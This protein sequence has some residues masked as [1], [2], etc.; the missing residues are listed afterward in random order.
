MNIK[1]IFNQQ[2]PAQN[3]QS[4]SSVSS[5]EVNTVII[6]NTYSARDSVSQIFTKYEILCDY[7][8]KTLEKHDREKLHRTQLSFINSIASPQDKDTILELIGHILPYTKKN[9]SAEAFKTVTDIGFVAMKAVSFTANV[10]TLG[11]TGK[12]TGKAIDNMESF[13]HRAI[14]RDAEEL[15]DAWRNKAECL[16]SDAKVLSGGFFSCDRQFKD[17][18]VKLE[19]QYKKTLGG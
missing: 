15:A 6:A 5:D 14:V 7:A 4:T 3:T 16:I 1:S 19:K 18:V 11:I 10:T 17:K 9:L 2:K 8:K 13:V 12:L